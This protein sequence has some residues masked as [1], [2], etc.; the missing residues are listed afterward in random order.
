MFRR[1]IFWIVLCAVSGGSI[2]FAAR[3]FPRAFPIVTLDLRMNRE[4]ALTGSREL[5]ARLQLPP[6]GYRQVASFGG[7]QET[8]NF[9]ELEAGGTGAFQAL[10][11]EGRYYPFTW[12]YST[13]CQVKK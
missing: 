7:D 2:F 8:Q 1:P 5:A 11:A 10:M 4:Q 12:F 3:Y 6:P 13:F 9:V